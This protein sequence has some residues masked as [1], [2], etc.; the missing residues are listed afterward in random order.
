[1]SINNF[2]G[3][4]RYVWHTMNLNSKPV[5]RTWPKACPMPNDPNSVIVEDENFYD[6]LPIAVSKNG[7]E[8]LVKSDFNPMNYNWVHEDEHPKLVG[9]YSKMS[10]ISDSN[11]E[12]NLYFRDDEGHY[13]DEGPH[14]K[15]GDLF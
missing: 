2:E 10:D 11:F 1:M 8:I 7:I 4:E 3:R 12:D 6:G 14:L 9:R 15:P 13:D 5:L